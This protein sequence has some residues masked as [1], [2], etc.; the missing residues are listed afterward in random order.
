M[1]IPTN[2]RHSFGHPQNETPHNRRAQPSRNALFFRSTAPPSAKC[3]AAPEAAA[4]TKTACRT[5]PSADGLQLR[6]RES[7]TR[8]GSQSPLP[9]RL[10]MAHHAKQYSIFSAVPQEVR[11][12]FAAFSVRCLP[13]LRRFGSVFG[14]CGRDPAFSIFF[15]VFTKGKFC[16][17]RFSKNTVRRGH[18]I[19]IA[20]VKFIFFLIFLIIFSK[21]C[22]F[23]CG[24]GTLDVIKIS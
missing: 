10:A 18:K 11:R 3:S 24:S 4:N 20:K 21:D 7:N 14:L 13:H 2:F 9:Y 23:C 22:I 19:H 12:I 6:Q 15:H 17:M 8:W 1:V 16:G 5:F